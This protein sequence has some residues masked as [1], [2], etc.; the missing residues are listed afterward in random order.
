MNRLDRSFNRTLSLE[1]TP[2]KLDCP[3]SKWRVAPDQALKLK[4]IPTHIEPLFQSSDDYKTKLGEFRAEISHWQ[5]LLYAIKQEALL[6]VFQGMDTAGKGGAIRH[7]MSGVNPQ[8][9]QVHS[10]GRPSEEELEHDFLWRCITRLP[11]RGMIGIFD[12]S[13]YEEVLVV[14]VKPEVLATQ[15]LPPALVQRKN[16]WSD[17]LD[18]I[19]QFET[20]LHRNGTKI[21]KFF[22]HV[23]PEEQRRRLLERIADPTKNWKFR[24]GDLDCRQHWHE[25]QQAYQDCLRHTSTKQAPWYVIPADD[26]RNARLIVSQV[27]LQTLE[28]MALELPTLSAAQAQDLIVAKQQLEKN[29]SV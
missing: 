23:S 13:Y 25:Y 8:G 5:S 7:V 9:C 3:I 2:V 27:I 20:Y 11:R 14:R 4:K 28:K 22:L 19:R 1:T 17:R 15:L 18:D 12:R 29:P 26:K 24:L 10:F 16:F 21:V 6:L